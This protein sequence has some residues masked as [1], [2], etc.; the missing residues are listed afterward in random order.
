MYLL[1]VYVSAVCS[2]YNERVTLVTKR[3]NEISAKYLNGA[4]I[5]S[6][7]VATFYVMADFSALPI[8]SDIQLQQLLRDQYKVAPHNVGVAVVPGCAFGLQATAKLVRFS[9]AVDLEALEL[10]MQIIANVV[11]KLCSNTQ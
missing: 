3:L 10:A 7:P 9:C 4:S 8:D 6:T 1:Y 5:A 11:E 2:H